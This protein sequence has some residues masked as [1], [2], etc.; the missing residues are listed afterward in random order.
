MTFSG[1]C[2][3]GD[4]DGEWIEAQEPIIR[5]AKKPRPI[6]LKTFDPEAPLELHVSYEEYRAVRIGSE[7]FWF[8]RGTT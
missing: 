5:F 2:V 6:A 8:L 3:G 4:H 7:V 1:E